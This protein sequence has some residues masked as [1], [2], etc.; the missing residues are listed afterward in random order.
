[1][2]YQWVLGVGL[3]VDLPNITHQVLGVC[4]QVS[5]PWCDRSPEHE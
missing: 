3:S 5:Q 1:M 2:G 4:A